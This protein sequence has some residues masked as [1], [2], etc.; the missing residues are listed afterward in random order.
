MA[1]TGEQSRTMPQPVPAAGAT[2][3]SPWDLAADGGIDALSSY[4]AP[5]EIVPIQ[6]E[7]LPKT[8]TGKVQRSVLRNT[9]ANRVTG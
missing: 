4:E 8:S 9:L 6:P 5:A 7:A 1:G 2:L 3:N